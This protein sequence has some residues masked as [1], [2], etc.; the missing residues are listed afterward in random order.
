MTDEIGDTPERPACSN[1]FHKSWSDDAL[2]ARLLIV[3]W[4]VTTG[5]TIRDVPPCELSEEELINFWAD[6]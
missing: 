3:T 6:D 5:R 1:A 4:R 2:M